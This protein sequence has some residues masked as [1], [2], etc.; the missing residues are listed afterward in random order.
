MKMI[1]EQSGPGEG[2]IWKQCHFPPVTSFSPI[3]LTSF[4]I[5][6]DISKED[7][8]SLSILLFSSSFPFPGLNKAGGG[9][10]RISLPNSS[11]S[12]LMKRTHRSASPLHERPRSWGMRCQPPPASLSESPGLH[13]S[14]WFCSGAGGCYTVPCP[15]QE[16]TATAK[17]LHVSPDDVDCGSGVFFGGGPACSD[18]T[19][20]RR[21]CLL[22]PVICYP[23]L[24][25]E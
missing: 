16:K 17:D 13:P 9:S 5:F 12:S 4:L 14:A 3:W 2:N 11:L 7:F 24:F 18:S 23:S 21:E 6:N 25:L 1:A 10:W 20:L 15:S 8:N 19:A 22:C